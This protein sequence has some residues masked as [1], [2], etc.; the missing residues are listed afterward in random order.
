MGVLNVDAGQQPCRPPRPYLLAVPILM[1]ILGFYGRMFLASAITGTVAGAVA[2]LL[3]AL[4]TGYGAAWLMRHW[5]SSLCAN[6]PLFLAII[7]I[8]L[9][10]DR[11]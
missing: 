3:W 11:A 2:G 5:R 4:L 7:A 9:M 10:T 8:G 6:T 1:T